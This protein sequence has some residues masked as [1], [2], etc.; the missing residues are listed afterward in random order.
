MNKI[1]FLLYLGII[2]LLLNIYLIKGAIDSYKTNIPFF[3][4]KIYLCQLK[5][6]NFP[7]DFNSWSNEQ[8]NIYPIFRLPKRLL[9][10][11]EHD[12]SGELFETYND[13]QLLSD[14]SKVFSSKKF[15]FTSNGSDYFFNLYV[16]TPKDEIPD[17]RYKSNEFILMVEWLVVRTYLQSFGEG[18]DAE[19]KCAQSNLNLKTVIGKK[20]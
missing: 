12:Y 8:K 5:F 7:P 17:F 18:T 10:Y 1:K 4:K 9:F 14:Y 6:Q 19:Y 3:Q 13:K 2:S 15:N 16:H 20:K 11:L